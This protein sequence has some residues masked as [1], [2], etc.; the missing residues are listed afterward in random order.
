MV[1]DSIIR[2]AVND[3]LAPLRDGRKQ[4]LLSS[5]RSF[6]HQVP[7]SFLRA[8]VNPL[9]A[10]MTSCVDVLVSL[11]AHAV[12]TLAAMERRPVDASQCVET[13]RDLLL[14]PNTPSTSV[15]KALISVAPSIP[16]CKLLAVFYFQNNKSSLFSL[17]SFET[18]P[19]LKDTQMGDDVFSLNITF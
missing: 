10:S 6:V 19:F 5:A 3:A 4:R 9:Q 7:L 12:D 18:M 14:T 16:G 2:L 13:T 17:A 11:A 8:F 1:T 15:G